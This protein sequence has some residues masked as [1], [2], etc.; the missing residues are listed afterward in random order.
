[1]FLM[2]LIILNSFFRYT[3]PGNYIGQF[4]ENVLP[5][6]TEITDG[7][8][9]GDENDTTGDN[10]DGTDSGIGSD[11]EEGSDHQQAG[12]DKVCKNSKYF[13]LLKN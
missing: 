2:Q 12:L 9:D 13:I 10:N 11:N 1:M 5:L 6:G 4:D 7:G 8:S 3:A